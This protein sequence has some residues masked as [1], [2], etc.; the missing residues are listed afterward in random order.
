MGSK[1]NKKQKRKEEKKKK[2]S[3]ILEE[4]LMDSA[5]WIGFTSFENS[6]SRIEFI[7]LGRP[8]TR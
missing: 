7:Y 3:S 4:G 5:S 6:A 1:N 8:S 2:L